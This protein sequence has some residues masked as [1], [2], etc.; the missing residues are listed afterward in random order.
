MP[1]VRNS[2]GDFEPEPAPPEDSGDNHRS[3]RPNLPTGSRWARAA[4]QARPEPD[5]YQV[6]GA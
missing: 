5:T 3:A 1:D 2:R 6:R 4:T